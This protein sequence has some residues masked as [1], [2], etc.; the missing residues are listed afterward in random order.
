MHFHLPL[1]TS[2]IEDKMS[3]MSLARFNGG[4]REA[5]DLA[6]GSLYAVMVVSSNTTYGKP[7][8]QEWESKLLLHI[9]ARPPLLPYKNQPFHLQRLAKS[10]AGVSH[11]LEVSDNRAPFVSGLLLFRCATRPP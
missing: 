6:S 5:M 7:V 11:F 1:V 2:M 4:G 3:C 9:C 10:T 8:R